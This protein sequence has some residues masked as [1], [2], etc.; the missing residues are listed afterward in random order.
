VATYTM[1]WNAVA[2]R[3]VLTSVQCP[4][5]QQE[6]D[7]GQTCCQLDSGSYGCCP[8]PKVLQKMGCDRGLMFSFTGTLY[9]MANEAQHCVIQDVPLSCKV[10]LLSLVLHI[11]QAYK[12]ITILLT[13]L[14][15]KV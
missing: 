8:Y 10:A 3:N 1:S 5:G 2:V 15:V 12:V 7:D 13:P 14:S 6:C 4:D 9:S 11:G